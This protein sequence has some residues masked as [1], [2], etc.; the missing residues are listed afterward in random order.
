MNGKAPYKKVLTHGFVT[1]GNGN[2]MS[3]SVGNVMDPL[4]ITSKFGADIL[5]L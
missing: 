5:R 2:K 1:D 4:E 3:K